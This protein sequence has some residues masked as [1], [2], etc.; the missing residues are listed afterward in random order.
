MMSIPR[1]H[2]RAVAGCRGGCFAFWSLS[3]QKLEV[4]RVIG[5]LFGCNNRSVFNN[6]SNVDD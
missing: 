5:A 4:G 1:S 3:K 6:N 2:L